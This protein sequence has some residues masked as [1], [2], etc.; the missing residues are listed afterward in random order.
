VTASLLDKYRAINQVRGRG[1]FRV[2]KGVGLG[3]GGSRRVRDRVSNPNPIVHVNS[4]LQFFNIIFLI[5]AWNKIFFQCRRVC[6]L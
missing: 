5:C 1:S 6:L 4:E 3:L 2:T